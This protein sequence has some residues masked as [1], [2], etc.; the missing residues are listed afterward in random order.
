[1]NG[2]TRFVVGNHWT[3]RQDSPALFGPQQPQAPGGQTKREAQAEIMTAFV[4]KRLTEDL[5]AW[6]VVAGD[7]NE[8]PFGEPL[9]ILERVGLT[10]LMAT[11]SAGERDTSVFAGNA[12][13]IDHLL[14]SAA[15]EERLVP[16]RFG[17][18]HVNAEYREPAS[19]HDP[20]VARFAL[21]GAA[22]PLP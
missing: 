6:M 17:V 2:Q 21:S 13:A 3:S 22:R 20:Q 11:L 7:C 18:V 15:L 12:Q 1:M 8:V 9:R 10:N 5:E 19:D 4:A 16:G 14:V